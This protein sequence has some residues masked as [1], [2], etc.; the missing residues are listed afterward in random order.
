MSHDRATRHVETDV[1]TYTRLSGRFEGRHCFTRI[2]PINPACQVHMR[3][4]IPMP[5]TTLMP[6][7]YYM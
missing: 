6:P 1:P 4:G 3:G 5:L 7:L 2:N